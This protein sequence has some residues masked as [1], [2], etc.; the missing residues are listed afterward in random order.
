MH[1]NSQTLWKLRKATSVPSDLDFGKKQSS[2]EAIRPYPNHA[3]QW[4]HHRHDVGYDELT[5]KFSII[6][7]YEAGTERTIAFVL[8][9]QYR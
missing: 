2:P 5:M 8:I 4:D 6:S 1:Q 7:L 3:P 9:L